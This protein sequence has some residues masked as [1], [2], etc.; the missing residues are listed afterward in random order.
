MKSIESTGHT[1][2]VSH[3]GELGLALARDRRHDAIVLDLMLP[4]LTGIEVCR[5]LRA[6]GRTVPMLMLT[7]RAAV[8]E[9]IRVS[10]P[11]P[12]TTW[13][14]RSRWASC[15]PGCAPSAGAEAVSSRM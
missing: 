11:A 2:E 13:S 7:A 14:S 9:R 8:S 1:V 15:G 4:R 12:T 3:D 5:R 6:D 10:T